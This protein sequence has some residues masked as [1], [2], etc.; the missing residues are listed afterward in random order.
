MTDFLTID[1]EFKNKDLIKA[2]KCTWDANS[3]SWIFKLTNT[4]ENLELL[5]KLSEE[6]IIKFVK[7]KTKKPSPMKGYSITTYTK[8]EVIKMKNNYDDEDECHFCGWRCELHHSHFQHAGSS[9]K[10]INTKYIITFD[11][12][13]ELVATLR[14]YYKIVADPFIEE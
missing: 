7:L 2:C 8:E 11:D 5:I 1:V 3:K 14:K 6:K 13:N 10:K 9:C 4:M 12:N